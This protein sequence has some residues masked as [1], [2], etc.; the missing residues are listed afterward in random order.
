MRRVVGSIVGVVLLAAGAVAGAIAFDRPEAPPPMPSVSDPF[1]AVDFSDLPAV[2]RFAARDGAALAY[3]RYGGDA[4]RVVVLIHGSAGS[5]IGMHAAAK[6]L[7]GAGATVIVPDLRGHGQSGP[8]GDIAYIGQLEDDLDDL[9]AALAQGH[10][11]RETT[12]IGFSAGG[13]FALRVAGGRLGS[14]FDRFILVAPFLGHDAPNARGNDAG[15]W[16]SVAVKR[17]V[18]LS[19]VN[20]LGITSFNGLPVIDFAVPAGNPDNLTARYSYRLLTNFQPDDDYVG[21]LRRTS[22]PI[23]AMDGA[24]DEVFFSGK[25]KGALEAGRPGIRVD[26]VPGVGH[27]GLTTTPA[28]TAAIAGAWSS[29]F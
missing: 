14:R 12:L 13:G 29:R 20:R 26:L 2:S 10:R 15:G 3:R 7:A 22:R 27:V 24:D 18:A 11:A 23:M 25:L 4:D 5:S 19:L 16:A 28:G 9:M 21:D 8:H 17:L 1:K 6:A